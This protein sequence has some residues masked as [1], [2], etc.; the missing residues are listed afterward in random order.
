MKTQ[1]GAL[2]T[3]AKRSHHSQQACLELHITKKLKMA[4]VS[5]Y[6][7]HKFYTKQGVCRTLAMPFTLKNILRKK[8]NYGTQIFHHAKI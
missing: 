2:S 6:P 5:L 1:Y 8:K 3:N 7:N 4:Y